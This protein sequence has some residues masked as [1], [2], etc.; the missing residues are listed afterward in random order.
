MLKTFPR[1]GVHPDDSKISANSPIKVSP[2]PNKVYVMLNQS[3]GAPAIPLVKKGDH[4]K[5]GQLIAKGEAFISANV[6]SPV[7]GIVDKIDQITDATG[8]KHQSIVINV[9]SQEIWEDGIDTTNDLLTDIK[10]TPQE[11][12]EKIKNAGIVGLGGAAFPTHVKLTIPQG[13]VAEYLLIN[14][15]ECE[16]YLTCDH[17]LMLEK[18]EE[19]M[20]GI[21]IIMK[22]LGVKKAFIGIENNKPDAIK[23][24]TSLSQNYSNIEVVPLK[25]K[26]PQGAEKQLIKAITGREVPSGKLPIEVGCVVQ[27]VAT[28]KAI[29]DA[30]QKNKPLIERV[31]TITGPNLSNPSNFLTRI[32]VPIN[33]LIELAGGLPEDTAKLISG[34]PMMGKALPNTNI[35]LTKGMGG[36]LLLPE[37]LSKRLDPYPCIRCGRCAHACPMG[38]EPFYLEKLIIKERWEEAEKHWIMDC[39]ECGS[40]QYTCPAK[41]PLLDYI[42]L[43]KNKVSAIIRSRKN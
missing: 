1:G 21:T 27:N 6:H 31:V 8:Y 38:L 25:K 40:C 18:S 11:I 39:M 9:E 43:G 17:R 10:A 16:P 42:R 19:I 4:I 29:Y 33:H 15:A 2:L 14:G 3:A 13:K 41:R 28:A 20:V 5:T 36:I 30:V 37:K 35:P 12:I 32:G 24:L 23:Q 34:G 26:Y 7:T 22:A